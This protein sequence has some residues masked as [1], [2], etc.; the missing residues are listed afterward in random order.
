MEYY[1][2]QFLMQSFFQQTGETIQGRLLK[3]TAGTNKAA[4]QCPASRLHLGEL[5]VERVCCAS[6]AHSALPSPSST[7]ST[8]VPGLKVNSQGWLSLLLVKAEMLR[9]FIVTCG[10]NKE[11]YTAQK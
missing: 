7:V 9:E 10:C 6:P 1:H 4:H 3:V 8:D 5:F 2:V 11:K